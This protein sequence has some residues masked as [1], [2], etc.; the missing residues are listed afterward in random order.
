MSS[1]EEKILELQSKVVELEDLLEYQQLKI[2]SK[3]NYL[4]GEIHELGGGY[5]AKTKENSK[6]KCKKGSCDCEK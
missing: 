1:N 2:R 3:L 6:Q 4:L 5:Q